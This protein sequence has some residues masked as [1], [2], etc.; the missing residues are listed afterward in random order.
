C[1][2]LEFPCSERSVGSACTLAVWSLRGNFHPIQRDSH[3]QRVGRSPRRGLCSPRA[4]GRIDVDCCVPSPLPSRRLHRIV[5]VACLDT[6]DF[7]ATALH[8]W[9]YVTGSSFWHPQSYNDKAIFPNLRGL[10]RQGLCV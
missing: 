6:S 7:S 2:L 10:L 4:G 8:R 9:G 5:L 3:L 1:T